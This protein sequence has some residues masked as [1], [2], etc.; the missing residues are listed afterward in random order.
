MRR[1]LALVIGILSV[2]AFLPALDGKFLTWD[3][4]VNFLTNESY[5]GLGWAQIRWAFS[6]VRMGHYIPLTWLSLSANYVAGG[7]NPWGYH[8]VSLLIHA[9]NAILF[10]LV[11]RRLL[12]AARDGGR[13]T[14]HREALLVAGAATAALVFALHPLRVESVAWITERRDVLSG[15]FFLAAILAYLRGVEA[16]LRLE[17]RWRT[18]SLL[19]FTAGLLSKASV[20]TLPAVL[21]LLDV[22]PLRRNAFTWRRLVVEKA[23]YWA[24]AL[25]GAVGALVALRLSGLRITPYA[26]YGPEARVAM[27]AYSFWFYPSTW[28]WPVR[29]SPMYEL[30][31]RLDPLSP[32]F[33]LPA[34]G[35]VAI[36]TLLVLLRKRWPGGLAAWV[37]SAMM[38]LPISG[39]VHAGFQLA[40]DR[41]SYLSG[42][43][44]ALV[45]GGAIAWILRATGDRRVSRPVAAGALGVAALGV[46]ALG[47]GSWQQSRVW[48]DSETLWRW[49]VEADPR[50]AICADN[51]AA[52][53]VDSDNAAQLREAEQLARY[54]LSI[55]PTHDSSY[56]TLGIVLA[57]RHADQEAEAAFRR[58]I[59]LAPDRVTPL[60]NLGILYARGGRHAEAVALLRA[61]FAKSPEHAGLRTHLALALRN[62]GIVQTRAGHFPEAEELFREA[63]D[64]TPDDPE[65]HRNLGLA[66]WERGRTDAAGAHLERAAALRPGDA[67][68]ER[69]L[70]Q[71]RADPGRPPKLR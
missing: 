21:V 43:G 12:A 19:L 68:A 38:L 61:A 57:Q 16:G 45:A 6:N 59:Q 26:A 67:E 23:G 47:V 65:I 70:A 55:D 1:L 28:A 29:L 30:P 56:N 2:V 35:L 25:A 27:V 11:A 3:D 41:Y 4:D 71:F 5:R 64:L 15:L 20:M 24:L 18:Y 33:L 37:Y 8:L 58:A 36:T 40:H 62:D 9:A 42:L 53:L 51:L 54:A 34:L 63:L 50:C 17:P 46:A 10:Y 22:Y 31:A 13:Q 48:L 52:L 60:V 14:A 7:M 39:V 44:F 49:G 69:L 66:L 32:R